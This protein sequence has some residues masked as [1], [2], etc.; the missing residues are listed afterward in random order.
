MGSNRSRN[1][2]NMAMMM[3][4]L[5]RRFRRPTFFFLHSDSEKEIIFALDRGT[6]E[7]WRGPCTSGPQRNSGSARAEKEGTCWL[8]ACWSHRL[9]VLWSSSRCCGSDWL[10]TSCRALEKKAPSDWIFCSNSRAG[11]HHNG[12]GQKPSRE[13]GRVNLPQKLSLP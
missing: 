8:K 2:W 10:A 9:K 5:W 4:P 6:F 11:F 12:R 13:T 3:C 1:I 7:S